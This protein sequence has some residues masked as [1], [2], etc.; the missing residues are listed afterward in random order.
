MA[1]PKRNVMLD[2][3]KEEFITTSTVNKNVAE[4]YRSLFTA[5]QPLETE[6]QKDFSEFSFNECLSVIYHDKDITTNTFRVQRSLIKNYFLWCIQKGYVLPSQ[7]SVVDQLFKYSPVVTNH[8]SRYDY[9][10]SAEEVIHIL[11]YIL[12]YAG[13]DDFMESRCVCIYTL[14]F[15]QFDYYDII[16]LQKDDID[17]NNRLIRFPELIGK[18]K[19]SRKLNPEAPNYKFARLPK[20]SISA[21]EDLLDSDTAMNA[22]GQEIQLKQSSY[23]FRTWRS[24]YVC[25]NWIHQIRYKTVATAQDFLPITDINKAWD[26]NYDRITQSG[27]FRAVY[28][29]CMQSS[30]DSTTYQRYIR[31]ILHHTTLK[32]RADEYEVWYNYT[33]ASNLR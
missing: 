22:N 19:E 16:N 28:D 10:G 31:D 8:G 7:K 21:F 2:D 33:I 23:L 6:L 30:V 26:L 24:E 14:F 12:R 15:L 20:D 5:S 1:K 17:I 18:K 3:R 13:I 32:A 29:N 27:R 11:R 4:R 25:Q 9:Y